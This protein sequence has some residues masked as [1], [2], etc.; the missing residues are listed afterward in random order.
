MGYRA[1]AMRK[2]SNLLYPI[3]HNAKAWE[4]GNTQATCRAYVSTVHQPAHAAPEETC[5]CGLHARTTLDGLLEEY[6]NYPHSNRGRFGGGKYISE[7]KTLILGSVLL[8]GEILR[9]EKV[10]RAEYGRPICFTTLPARQRPYPEWD[11]LAAT[12]S[13]TYSTPIIEW[14]YVELFSSEFGDLL[15]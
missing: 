13:Q 7:Y 15:T 14:D 8:W 10:I 11:D 12:V 2:G 4:I 6:P 5:T 1:W 3:F 9:G